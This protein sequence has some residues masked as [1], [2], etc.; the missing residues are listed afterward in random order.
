[1]EEKINIYKKI[2]SNYKYINRKYCNNFINKQPV[3]QINTLTRHIVN[4]PIL[5][6]SCGER[7]SS[8][9]I[10]VK[11][12]SEYKKGYNYILTAIDYFSRKYGPN[13]K[14]IK[15]HQLY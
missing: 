7:L 8:N 13:H 6:S 1:M 3:Y 2:T 15:K 5:S 12:L 11:N 10:S 14:R 9:L 4:K